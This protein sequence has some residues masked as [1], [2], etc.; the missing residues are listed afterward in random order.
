[1]IGTDLSCP[2][3][4]C[5]DAVVVTEKPLCVNYVGEV[6]SIC[7]RLTIELVVT[8][9]KLDQAQNLLQQAPCPEKALKALEHMLTVLER[10][11]IPTYNLQDGVVEVVQAVHY[12]ARSLTIRTW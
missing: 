10:E 3:N 9:R 6:L 2:D 5:K 11:K 12:C 7:D 4:E 8:E 1:M